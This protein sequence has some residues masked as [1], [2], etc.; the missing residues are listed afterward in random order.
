MR[1]PSY[2]VGARIGDV[3]VG[4]QPVCNEV[5]AYSCPSPPEKLQHEVQILGAV[6]IE[7]Y[8]PAV[9]RSP[10]EVSQS[11]EEVVN[12]GK[13]HAKVDKS[14]HEG[15]ELVERARASL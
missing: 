5:H 15:V 1:E 10:L 7:F 12:R 9:C 3:D 11:T 6:S 13:S 2:A 14:T 4:R 8:Q